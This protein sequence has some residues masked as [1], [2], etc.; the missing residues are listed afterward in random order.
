MEKKRL[1]AAVDLPPQIKTQLSKLV[2]SWQGHLP[3]KPFWPDNL[4]L[5]F[6]FLGNISEGK[7]GLVEHCLNSTAQAREPFNLQ[8]ERIEPGPNLKRPRLMWLT[9]PKAE[10]LL[11]LKKQTAL[12]L[13]NKDK[14]LFQNIDQKQFLGHTHITL[15]RFKREAKIP[16][17]ILSKFSVAFRAILPVKA[18]SLYES[19]L[20]P[21]GPVYTRIG[22]YLLKNVKQG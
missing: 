8:A 11:E 19:Q 17:H 10:K 13:Q 22:R 20:T 7:L 21:K 3:L 2:R 18:L 14:E 1:F 9:I 4:H 5:T 12:C 15:V 6:L 16:G